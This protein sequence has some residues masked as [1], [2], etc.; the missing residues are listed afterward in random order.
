MF[1]KCCESV[2]ERKSPQPKYTFG[3]TEHKKTLTF[4]AQAHGLSIFPEVFETFLRF[5]T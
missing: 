1:E 3:P 5:S 2:F 4:S